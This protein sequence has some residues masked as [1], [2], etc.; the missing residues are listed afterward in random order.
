MWEGL[1]LWIARHCRRLAD[2]LD[3][4]VADPLLV[5]ARAIVQETEALARRGAYK[6]AVAQT[7]LRRQFPMVTRRELKWAIE[8]AVHERMP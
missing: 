6:A 5:A 7:Q 4:P 8:V 2:W 1:C 3:P